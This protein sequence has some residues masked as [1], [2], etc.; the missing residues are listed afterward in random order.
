[1]FKKK[2]IIISVSTFLLSSSLHSD[3]RCEYNKNKKQ[4][5]NIL[6]TLVTTFYVLDFISSFNKD[7]F[8][9]NFATAVYNKA[10][11]RATFMR[12][13]VIIRTSLG[14]CQELQM[15]CYAMGGKF[16]KR[17]DIRYDDYSCICLH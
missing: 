9:S 15:N 7:T 6:S 2:L 11:P 5:K 16:E 1:M 12:D 13:E 14:S 17:G 3:Q 8:T 4:K 10:N